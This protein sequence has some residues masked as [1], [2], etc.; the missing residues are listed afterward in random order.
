MQCIFS[1]THPACVAIADAAHE[2]GV[3]VPEI[4]QT[5]VDA[6]SLRSASSLMSSPDD[7]YPLLKRLELIKGLLTIDPF[8]YQ[9]FILVSSFVVFLDF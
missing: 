9:V 1:L 5:E 7:S 3:P 4:P 8:W 2:A 6:D